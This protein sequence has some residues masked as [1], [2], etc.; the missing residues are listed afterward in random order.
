MKTAGSHSFTSG[1]PLPAR[2]KQVERVLLFYTPF[3]VWGPDMFPDLVGRWN[4]TITTLAWSFRAAMCVCEFNLARLVSGLLVDL[5]IYAECIYD[6]FET[7]P[8]EDHTALRG[9]AVVP[10]VVA[11]IPR[12]SAPGR[13]SP[14]GGV[15][16]TLIDLPAGWESVLSGELKL[17]I[18]ANAPVVVVPTEGP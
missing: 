15:Y 5:D 9:V 7:T 11:A 4:P 12:Y 2:R 17:W 10:E 14:L 13:C 16:A 18:I 3:E 6:F 1:G 8:Y